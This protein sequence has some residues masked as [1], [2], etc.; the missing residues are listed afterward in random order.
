MACL[1]KSIV[2]FSSGLLTGENKT[3]LVLDTFSASQFTFN[4]TLFNVLSI[5]SRSDLSK[6]ML[7]SSANK[8]KLSL[9][10]IFGKS[11]IYS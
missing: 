2:T 4:Q 5:S 1:L 10:N 11:F 8:K 9:L 7:V 3:K 6:N